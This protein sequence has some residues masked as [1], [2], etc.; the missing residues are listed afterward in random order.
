M[1]RYKDIKEI[2]SSYANK[3]IEFLDYR[4]CNN[5]GAPSIAY[6]IKGGY[7]YISLVREGDY[8]SRIVLERYRGLPKE[9]TRNLEGIPL[10]TAKSLI[11]KFYEDEDF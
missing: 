10:N 8:V 5:M 11:N 1:M 9:C 3:D 7:G 2:I 6:L 4:N